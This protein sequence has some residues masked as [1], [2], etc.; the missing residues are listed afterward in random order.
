M[1]DHSST[2][3]RQELK[4]GNDVTDMCGEEVSNYFR[5]NG[6]YELVNQEISDVDS[7]Y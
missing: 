7:N 3:A 6:L 5:A 2:K 1:E 4:K